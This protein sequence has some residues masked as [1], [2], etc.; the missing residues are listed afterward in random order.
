MTS[1]ASEF[2]QIISY[3]DWNK[4]T[5]KAHFYQ[6]LKSKI[7]T[8]ILYINNKSEILNKIIKQAIYIDN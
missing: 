5:L 3:L 8:G 4:P 6:S 2:H 7:K 1:Y